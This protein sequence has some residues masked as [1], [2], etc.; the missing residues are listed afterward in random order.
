[1]DVKLFI[2]AVILIYLS[3]AKVLESFPFVTVIP[4]RLGHLGISKKVSQKLLIAIDVSK[5]EGV[6]VITLNHL[7]INLCMH[8]ASKAKAS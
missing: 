4:G 1:M 2:I 7:G 3:F 8:R 5:C 6:I